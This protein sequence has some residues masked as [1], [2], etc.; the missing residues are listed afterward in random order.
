MDMGVWGLWRLLTYPPITFGVLIHT[1]KGINLP[2]PPY[3]RQLNN[4]THCGYQGNQHA[5]MHM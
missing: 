2:A 3:L 4:D 5:V 1:W